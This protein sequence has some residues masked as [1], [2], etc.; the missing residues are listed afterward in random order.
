MKK[1]F[2]IIPYYQN[3]EPECLAGIKELQLSQKYEYVIAK[4]KAASLV[5]ARNFAAFQAVETGADWIVTIDSDIGFTEDDIIHCIKLGKDFV[6]LPYKMKGFDFYE[7]AEFSK[8]GKAGIQEK[9]P[10]TTKGIRKIKGYAGCGFH[11]FKTNMLKGMKYPWYTLPIIEDEKS[12]MGMAIAG[13]DMGF[14]LNALE[15]NINL[16]VDFDSPV[17]HIDREDE[18]GVSDLN[19][20]LTPLEVGYLLKAVDELPRKIANSLHDKISKQVGKV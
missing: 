14:C 7:C 6:A 5:N 16:Y 3:I 19:V 1:I 2:V 13:E 11:V 8:P 15:S 9:F 18:K 10:L 17:T 20:R 4:V 12:P